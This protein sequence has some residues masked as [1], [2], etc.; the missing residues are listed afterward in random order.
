MG[1]SSLN[2]SLLSSPWYIALNLLQ[3]DHFLVVFG[4]S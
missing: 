3:K 2:P 1:V 4:M